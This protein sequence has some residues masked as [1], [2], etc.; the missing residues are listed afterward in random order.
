MSDIQLNDV[1]IITNVY[2]HVVKRTP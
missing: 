1:I 2:A